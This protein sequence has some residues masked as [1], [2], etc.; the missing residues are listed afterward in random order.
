MRWSGIVVPP[1]RDTPIADEVEDSSACQRSLA[2]RGPDVPSRVSAE[3]GFRLPCSSRPVLELG[4]GS[5]HPVL[6]RMP[7]RQTALPVN[8]QNGREGKVVRDPVCE[9]GG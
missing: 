8:S 9:C 3:A 1:C 2:A 7:V 5:S 4:Q 6:D